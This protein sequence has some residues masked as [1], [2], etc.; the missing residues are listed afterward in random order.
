MIK[1]A[2]L[3]MQLVSQ[4]IFRG[5]FMPVLILL[6]IVFNRYGFSQTC[7]GTNVVG[8]LLTCTGSSGP[9]V[10]AGGT[11]QGGCPATSVSGGGTVDAGGTYVRWGNVAGTYTVYYANCNCSG[12]ITTLSQQVRVEATPLDKTVTGGGSRC[13]PRPSPTG[14][15]T[16]S[17]SS[18]VPSAAAA[19]SR[20]L[21]WGSAECAG[22][23]APRSPAASACPAHRPRE[24]A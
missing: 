18:G 16:R 10:L 22:H 1:K 13:A 8:S 5:K 2:S 14:A 12:N 24:T 6:M 23:R 11:I 21:R 9:Y 4:H 15:C 17:S 20:S 7:G 19:G 3:S